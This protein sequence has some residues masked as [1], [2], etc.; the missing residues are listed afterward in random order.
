MKEESDRAESFI[1]RIRKY[2]ITTGNKI[3]SRIS[4]DPLVKGIVILGSGTAI[5]QAL[6]IL[7]VPI[8]TRIFPPAIYGTLAVFTSLLSILIVASSFKYELTIPIA[9][10][11][12]DAEYLLILSLF[13]V[14]TLTL[15]LFLVMIVWG[16]FLAGTFHFEFI[17][18]YY[19]LF[20][21]GFFG[22]SLYQVLTF[23]T[24][25]TKNYALITQTRVA[26][27]ISSSVSKI[28]LGLLSL[29]SLGLISGEI[30][31]R[32]VGISTLGKTILPKAWR[33][34]R[35]L[36]VPAMRALAAKY[37]KFPGFSMPAGFINEIILQVPTL[38]LASVFGFEIVGLYMLSFSM[39]ELP[40]SLISSSIAQAFF[41]ESSELLRNKSDKILSLYQ[42]T[43]KKLFMFGAPIIFLGA[44]ISPIV[45]PIVFGSAWK[46][47]GM[48]SIPLSFMVVAGFVVSSTDRLEL[49]GF[50]QWELA[51]NIARTIL[52]LSGLYLCYLFSLSPVATIL[53]YSA[54]MTFMYGVCY[55]LNVKAIHQ[56]LKKFGTLQT[57][58][59]QSG[60]T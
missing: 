41:G 58:D 21:L 8:L 46:D 17:A 57:S 35:T 22:M 23:W 24:L 15:I 56:V 31:G 47:A 14:C 60:T 43:T 7:F 37:K 12:T 44:I 19:W 45:F 27:S 34:I 39:L 3:V 33:T 28:I 20:G 11:D 9:E 40:V 36:D 48:F 25:R 49:L 10:N 38:Y 30:I 13:I 54:I 29:G 52:V 53:V 1:P 26:Q 16:N 6:G 42:K 51:W 4:S 18:P 2:L 55:L 50:N 32:F 5:S 59:T